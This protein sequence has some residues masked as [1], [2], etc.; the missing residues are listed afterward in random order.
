VQY[1]D[2]PFSVTLLSESYRFVGTVLSVP[3]CRYRFVGTVLSESYRFVFYLFFL[4][5]CRILL[6]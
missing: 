5:L 3:F 2:I 1:V 6:H 4:C